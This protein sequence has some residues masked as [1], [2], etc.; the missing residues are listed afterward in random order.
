MYLALELCLLVYFTY[1]DLCKS[2]DK[3]V[4]FYCIYCFCYCFN[5]GREEEIGPSDNRLN[6]Q[7]NYHGSSGPRGQSWW[8]R[9]SPETLRYRNLD[10]NRPL[11]H[12]VSLLSLPRASQVHDLNVYFSSILVFSFGNGLFLTHS[13]EITADVKLSLDCTG[14]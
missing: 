2:S 4:P 8:R 14:H 5:Y 10:S 7:R 9:P 3:L 6:R 1:F 13:I 12:P 11:L